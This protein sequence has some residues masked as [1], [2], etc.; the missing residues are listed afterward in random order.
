M[1]VH[2]FDVVWRL[3]LALGLS[4]VIGIEREIRQKSAGL[5]TYAL[6]GV[7]SALFMLVSEY[8]FA[9]VI[10]KHVTLDPSRVAAQVVSGIGFIG[11][12]VIFVRRDL[13]RGL[14][15]AAGVWATAA[16]GMAAG[17]DL[18]V[19]AC[20][21]TVIYLLVSAG[22]PELKDLLPH[23][24]FATSRVRLTYNDGQGVLRELLGR[25]SEHGFAVSDLIVERKSDG[26]G[27]GRDRTVTVRLEVRGSGSVPEL[28]TD[29][30]TVDGVL[31]VRTA[32]HG[33]VDVE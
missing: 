26:N 1:A 18:P 24:R 10:G 7:G 5:R 6:V 21:T 33:E 27:D 8:G 9:D 13:V 11:G 20:A 4:S 2:E 16:I 31:N 29:L 28:A 23:S 30:D 32:G 14:T 3:L 17:G 25:C 15:T 12:G 22:Y 19:L